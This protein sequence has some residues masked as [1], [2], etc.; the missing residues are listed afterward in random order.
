MYL[1]AY[2]PKY[3]PRGLGSKTVDFR[4][5]ELAQEALQQQQMQQ[6]LSFVDAL[7]SMAQIIL[8]K[9]DALKI[10]Q[11]ITDILGKTLAVDHCLIYA[12]DFEKHRSIG[13]CEWLNP[14]CHDFSHT[15]TVHNLELFTNGC[16]YPQMSQGW[17]ESHIDRI[18]PCLKEDDLAVLLHKKRHIKSL[19]WY[20]FYF[21]QEGY[22]LLVF[23]QISER[24]T[25]QEEE[26]SFI[27]A[28]T[29]QVSIAF[30]KIQLLT[31]RQQAEEALNKTNQELENR[32]AERTVEL[33]NIIERLQSQNAMSKASHKE[34]QQVE[35]ALQI[36]EQRF[37][38]VFEKTA[39]GMGLVD[40]TGKLIASNPALHKIIGYSPEELRSMTLADYTHP[41]DIAYDLALYQELLAGKR[42]Y[43]QMEKRFLKKKGELF[44]GR[45]T[46]SAI[47]CTQGKIQFTF[48]TVEDINERKQAEEALRQSEARF[49]GFVEN[50]NDIIY[51]LTAEG[52]LSYVSP[53]WTDI[54]GHD[55][56]E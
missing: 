38:A 19:L 11:G 33:R 1:K 41:D 26:I 46:V 39:I 45:L 56:S 5:S 48:G 30:Q 22:Y 10:L 43:Y 23:H 8:A 27:N 44:W 6:P 36:S 14:Q 12:I 51:S 47:R 52:I 20:P 15:N 9:E 42:D 7:N 35:E 55:V 17:L 2:I 32:V 16:Q 28:A 53:N 54:L 24:R 37:R 18:N 49:R 4:E 13:L 21:S 3:K 40:V 29:N 34:T 25:W 31:E 50:A